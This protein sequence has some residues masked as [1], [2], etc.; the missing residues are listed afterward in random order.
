MIEKPRNMLLTAMKTTEWFE[1]LDCF[2][3]AL[4]L[5]RGSEVVVIVRFGYG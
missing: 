1:V 2:L 3:S 4:C 5:S